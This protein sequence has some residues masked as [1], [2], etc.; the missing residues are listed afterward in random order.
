MMSI[1]KVFLSLIVHSLL[2]ATLCQVIEIEDGLILGREMV[3]RS[4]VTFNA[5]LGIPFARPPI[6]ALRF[7]APVRNEPWDGILN[8]T[9]FGPMCMQAGV[10]PFGSEDC[11][12]LNVF[13][14]NLP[15]NQTVELKPVIVFIHGGGFEVF[16][17]NEI[18]K[19]PI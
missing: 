4:N 5:F 13:T 8:C 16:I 17:L 2:G 15:N 6:G 11:L 7:Q 3:T 14:K 10:G 18:V 12:Q 9:M 19:V 1:R